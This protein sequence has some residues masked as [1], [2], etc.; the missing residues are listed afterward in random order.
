MGPVCV[1]MCGNQLPSQH[2]YLGRQKCPS[3]FQCPTLATM[4]LPC[5]LHPARSQTARRAVGSIQHECVCADLKQAPG[6]GT[7]PPFP[8]LIIRIP[9]V[10]APMASLLLDEFVA[11]VRRTRFQ[12]QGSQVTSLRENKF[13]LRSWLL[14][15]KVKQ[16]IGDVDILMNNAGVIAPTDLLSMKDDDVQ[17][18]FD[19]NILSHYWVTTLLLSGS[20]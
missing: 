3:K 6:T 14:V 1:C 12:L 10:Q 7:Q 5:A 13:N 18:T 17:R 9:L 20:G 8:P 15:K 16:E 11:R 2:S 19:V 4:T